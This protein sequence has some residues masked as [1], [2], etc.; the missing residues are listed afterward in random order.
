[1]SSSEY[2]WSRKL[3]DGFGKMW[4]LL[5]PQEADS[6]GGGASLLGSV[7]NEK[8]GGILPSTGGLIGKDYPV[9]ENA[10]TPQLIL[11]AI[12][13]HLSELGIGADE[14]VVAE[15]KFSN[16]TIK[17]EKEHSI[18]LG[19][20]DFPSVNASL[21]VDY[22]RMESISIQFGENTRKLIIPT[23]YLSRLKDFVGGDHRKLAT[24]INIDKEMIINEILLTDQYTVSFN[25]TTEFG[26]DF[27]AS[28]Q[29]ANTVSA[30][31]VTFAINQTNKR[32]VSAIVNDGKDYLIALDGID[33][34]K[35]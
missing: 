14:P 4:F 12:T 15:L 1:M 20:G 11:N 30:G 35:F 24:D 28:L 10:T 21:K 34:D 32:Q 7:V 13:A 19:G 22:K 17:V 2:Y 5:A 23:G 27:E 9:P 25:S 31:A 33:W 8:S 29:A 16:R 3:I 6:N 26:S 18:K